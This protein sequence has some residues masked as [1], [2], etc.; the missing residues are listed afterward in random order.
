MSEAGRSEPGATG[1]LLWLERLAIGAGLCVLL[2]TGFAT[3]SPP[4]L[5]PVTTFGVGWEHGVA[6]GLLGGCWGFAFPRRA[7]QVTL[8]LVLA[9]IILEVGQNFVPGRHARVIDA[10][11]KIAGGC[12]GIVLAQFVRRLASR[13]LGRT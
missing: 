1:P 3:W 8:V 7:I 10:A 9:A 13:R 11:T 12:A 5:R 6:F 2:I 4:D